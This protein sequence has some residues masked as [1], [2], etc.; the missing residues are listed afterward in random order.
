MQEDL[1]YLQ[2]ENLK[3]DEEA[4]KYLAQKLLDEGAV[5]ESFISSI[6]ER[7]KL[8]PTGLEFAGYAVAIPHTD[9]EHVKN[10]RVALMTLKNT[11]PF[12]E[13]AGSGK[14]NVNLIVMLAIKEAHSQVDMLRRLIELLQD[15]E[16]V[17]KILSFKS[18]QKEEVLQILSAHKII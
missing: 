4:L 18:E 13:M 17:Q 5:K 6:Y 11:V 12:N 16:K 8:A 14:V 3:S 2:V 10:T 1:I 7:E 15:G 9:S